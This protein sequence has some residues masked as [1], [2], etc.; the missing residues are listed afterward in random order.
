MGEYTTISPSPAN[1]T[2][3]LNELPEL[4][5]TPNNYENCFLLDR[6]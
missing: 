5:V 3:P 2:Y 1:P 4:D 6:C